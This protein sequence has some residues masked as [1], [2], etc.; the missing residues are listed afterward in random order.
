MRVVATESGDDMGVSRLEV[1]KGAR[2]VET[3][4]GGEIQWTCYGTR[5]GPY[6]FHHPFVP[7]DA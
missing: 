1:G 6:L 3:G 2:G 7:I 4:K 5:T